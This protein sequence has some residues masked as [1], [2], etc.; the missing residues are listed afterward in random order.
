MVSCMVW[1]LSQM[2][3]KYLGRRLWTIPIVLSVYL[4]LLLPPSAWAA[5]STYSALGDLTRPTIMAQAAAQAAVPPSRALAPFRPAPALKPRTAAAGGASATAAAGP[6]PTREVFG[7]VNA[8]NIADP[9]VGYTGWNFS[10]L[11]TVAFF[12]LHVNSADGSLVTT[13]TGWAEWSSSDLTN[14]LAAAHGAGVRVVVSI[15]LQDFSAS[16]TTMCQGLQHVSATISQVAAQVSAKGVDGVNVDYEGLNASCGSTT[17]AALLTS[18]VGQLRSALSAGSYLSIDTYASSAGAPGGFFDVGGLAASVD[19]FFVMAYDLD[20]SN[21]QSAPLNCASYCMN[22]VAPLTTYRFNDTATASQYTGVVPASKVILGV[23][24]YGRTACVAPPGGPRPGPNAT[25]TGSTVTPTYLDAVAAPTTAGVSAYAAARDT[26]DLAGQEPFAT[27]LSDAAHFN[28]WRE[29]YWD[30]PVSLGQKYALVGQDGL[31]GVGIFTLDY[32]GS[33]PELWAALTQAFG[34]QSLGGTVSASPAVASWGA[35][36]LDVFVRW[37]DGSLRHSGWAGG[38]WSGWE[39]LGGSFIGEPSVVSWGPNRLDV[40]VRGTDNSLWHLAWTGSVW[41][42]WEG[43]GGTMSAAPT[44]VSWGANR[45]DVF[46]RGAGAD[47][48]HKA[49]TGSV[50]SDWE[51]LGGSMSGSPGGVS[52]GPNRIDVFVRGTGADLWHKAWAG[53]AWSGW[54]GLGGVLGTSPAVVSWGPN[55]LDALVQGTDASVWDMTWNGAAW[56]PWQPLQGFLS[57]GP[58][59]A[60]PGVGRLDVYGLGADTALWHTLGNGAAWGGWVSLGG[61]WASD[62]PVVVVQPGSMRVDVFVVGSGGDVWHATV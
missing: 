43:L 19:S 37:T 49:W 50:W 40:F 14:L 57:A 39:N 18:F 2:L 5:G 10:L 13:D 22:P 8:G 23:P 25:D 35:N 53:S 24:Y 42:G 26:N 16:N 27:W 3:L 32:G 1:C 47:L 28:C 59:A 62:P 31:R 36:R 33:A 34:F 41:S 11:S 15:I 4:G 60:A 56:T 52:W 9:Q 61:G 29:S 38:A 17:T 55:R 58:A 12:G 20:Q 46:L 21:F 54:E 6:G 51:G 45:L 48:W 7:F 30:D 44:V